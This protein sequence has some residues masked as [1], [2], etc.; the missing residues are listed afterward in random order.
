MRLG[1]HFLHPISTHKKVAL[2]QVQQ[3]TVAGPL[4]YLYLYISIYV[5]LREGI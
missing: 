2:P 5:S 4:S 3:A 1:A